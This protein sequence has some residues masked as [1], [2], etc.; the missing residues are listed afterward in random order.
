M[1]KVV[2][3]D[4]IGHLLFTRDPVHQGILCPRKKKKK[5]IEGTTLPCVRYGSSR[6]VKNEKQLAVWRYVGLGL[7][8]ITLYIQTVSPRNWAITAQNPDVVK[9]G[10]ARGFVANITYSTTKVIIACSGVIQP[11]EISMLH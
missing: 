5:K 8:D 6:C 1:V 11:L 3:S 2:V 9:A 7:D 4:Q 10:A